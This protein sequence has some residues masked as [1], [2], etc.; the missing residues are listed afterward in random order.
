MVLAARSVSADQYSKKKC[1]KNV[2]GYY[3]LLMDG[4]IK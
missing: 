4:S 3:M 2:P 1:K